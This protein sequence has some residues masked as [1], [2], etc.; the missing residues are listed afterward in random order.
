MGDAI[1]QSGFQESCQMAAEPG[2][3]QPI[4]MAMRINK[5]WARSLH[6]IRGLV[7]PGVTSQ[8]RFNFFAKPLAVSAAE[9]DANPGLSTT[10]GRPVI[11]PDDFAGNRKPFRIFQQGQQ[12]KDFIA[13][14]KGFLRR[15]ENPPPFDKGHVI[16]LQH[17]LVPDGEGDDALSWTCHGFSLV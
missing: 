4:Q 15:D 3:I 17:P 7:N 14:L 11:D 1:E 13:Q 16:V 5:H 12:K 10:R 9:L 6:R 8:Q 2:Q